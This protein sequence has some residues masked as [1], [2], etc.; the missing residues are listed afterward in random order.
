MSVL[1]RQYGNNIFYPIVSCNHVNIFTTAISYTIIS[2]WDKVITLKL[3]KLYLLIY[4]IL[5]YN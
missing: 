3:V 4:N 2:F 1:C 5:H